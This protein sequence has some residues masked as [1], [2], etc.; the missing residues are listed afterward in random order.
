MCKIK[1]LPE[2]RLLRLQANA[3]PT[4]RLRV[5]SRGHAAHKDLDV[6]VECDGL[7]TPEASKRI[8]KDNL[9]TDT[10]KHIQTTTMPSHN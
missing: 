3:G 5:V 2:V 4:G 1:I 6:P 9:P 8:P 7:A 10:N